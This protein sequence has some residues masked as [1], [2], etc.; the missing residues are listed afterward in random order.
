MHPSPQ[1]Q[2]TVAARVLGAGALFAS[3]GIH[4]DLYLTGYHSIPTIGPLFI[5]QVIGT[6]SVAVVVLVRSSRLV[7]ANGALLALG[8]LAGYLLSRAVGIFGFREVATTAGLVS[9]L[10]ETSA[11]LLLGLLAVATGA[12]PVQRATA[13]KP[14]LRADGILASRA[15]LLTVPVVSVIAL[16]LSLVA[17]TDATSSASNASS[18]PGA[19]RASGSHGSPTIIIENFA[20]SPSNLTVSPHE[21]IRVHNEDS[22]AHT[23]TAVPGS[24]PFGNFNTGDIGQD[25]AK[26]FTAPSKKGTYQYYC[27]IH[28]FMTGEIT[29]S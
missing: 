19:P 5:V 6:F 4:L 12:S 17:G 15:A 20:F 24:T 28:N 3:G 14:L 8:T 7:A 26:S 27:S 23:V 21:Q 25:A 2:A 29:V 10:L 22:V 16:A 1:R 11:F 13:P 9:G 18:A